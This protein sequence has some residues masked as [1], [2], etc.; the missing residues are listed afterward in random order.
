MR[1]LFVLCSMLLLLSA[2]QKEDSPMPPP[3]PETGTEAVLK[4]FK[5]INAVPRPSKHEDKIRNYLSAFAAGRNLRCINDNG[6][7]I[8]YK[9][10]TAGMEDAPSVCLQSHM[11]MVC[12][13]AEGYEIDFLTQGIEQEVDGDVIHSKG[14]KTSLGAD[15]G[16]GVATVLA[17]LDNK[18]IAHGPLEC[19]FTWDEETGFGGAIALTPGI[20]KSPYLFNIDWE[21]GG[22]MCIGTSGGLC[23]DITLNT[24]PQ[25]APSTYVAYQLEVNRLTGGHSGVDITEGHANAIVLLA[26]FLSEQDH[27]LLADY[28]G[29]KAANAI[30]ANVSATVLV[31]QADKEAFE[32]AYNTYMAEMKKHHSTKDPDMYYGIQP[33]D[34]PATCLDVAQSKTIIEGLAKA[35][36]DVIEWSW[37]VNG[38]FE[39]SDNVGWVAIQDGVFTA[40]YLIRGFHEPNIADAAGMIETAWNVG[41]SGAESRRFGSFSA[42]SPELTTPVLIYAQAAYQKTFDKPIVLRK[43][44]AGL[45]LSEFART[46]PD[47]QCLSFGPTIH[48]PH[49]VIECVEIPSVEETWQFLIALIQDIKNLSK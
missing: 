25:V 20:I 49:S 37:E 6:N 4:F 10:A 38:A 21:Q 14:Y 39:T 9:D 15:D 26:R 44:G 29:G 43:I 12:V 34:R 17:L 46:Y 35:P 22:E 27:V 45:E 33:L 19:L 3:Q 48:N 42:W 32:N 5:E 11:D 2:C 41:T 24:S 23:V 8:I 36:Q 31:P 40:K 13:A 30:A 7:I 28:T 16:I 1:K 18:T 47:L